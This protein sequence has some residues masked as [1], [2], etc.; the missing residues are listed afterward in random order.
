MRLPSWLAWWMVRLSMEIAILRLCWRGMPWR[1]ARRV[2][3]EGTALYIMRLAREKR[4]V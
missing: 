3:G 1:Q 2:I 4:G